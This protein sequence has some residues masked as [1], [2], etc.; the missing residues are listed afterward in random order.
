MASFSNLAAR[1]DSPRLQ[2]V[3]PWLLVL[4]ALVLLLPSSGTM[5]LLDRDEPRFAEATREMMVGEHANWAVPYFNGQYRFD[6]PVLIY[7]MMWPFY[8]AFGVNEFSARLPSVLCTAAMAW[9]LWHM[10]RRWFSTACGV[11][12]GFG[13]VTCVQLLQHGRGVLADMPM[14]LG[15]TVAH[16]AVF[17]LLHAE[18]PEHSRRWFLLLYGALGLG[19]L[20][21]G[22]VTLVVPLL[23]VLM[24]RFIFWRQPL[25]WRNLRLE[26]GLPLVLLIIAA[27]GIPAVIR[28][29]GL[30]FKI[31][32]GEHVVGRGYKTFQGHGGF[33]FYYLLTAILSLFPW[34]AF[35]GGG[36][37][38]VRRNWDSRNAFLV[39]WLAGTYLLFSFY[40]TKLPHYVIP[41]FPAFFLII[42]QLAQPQV[43]MPRWT[44][45]WFWGVLLLG[46]LIAGAA[47]GEVF[48][49]PA[50]E[51]YSPLRDTLAGAGCIILALIV[52]AVLWRFGSVAASVVP[53]IVVAGS[54]FWLGSGLR[55]V[56]PALRLQQLFNQM[57]ADTTY[58]GYRFMEP[59]L[60]FYADHL[61]EPVGSVDR[62]KEFMA[63][64]GPRLAV[65]TERE[66]RPT[67]YFRWRLRGG[68]GKPK[69][70]SREAEL[71]QIPAE[72]YRESVV[73][74]FDVANSTWVT[75]R[76]Y[77]RP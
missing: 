49:I 35:A 47:L 40:T 67:D 13:F 59:S 14:I 30:F 10:G 21:K 63:K 9:L 46:A 16:Y 50:G 31:G 53:L 71:A 64:P 44:C 19:F 25:R 55:A 15:V 24:Y 29:H 33:V 28:T 20:A 56:T 61:W 6:K 54:M 5:P 23:T 69:V 62:L 7:W 75:L 17:E 27:W 48:R 74:G 68:Q 73:D 45:V 37:V 34:I 12:A 32:I 1:L 72:G 77:Q 3:A 8:L 58:G 66:I 4:V 22:P 11:F 57:P 65:C 26:L 42:G 70:I 76:V 60:V 39:S 2:R 41:A 36:A 38:V 52:L 51:S 43:T 18:R